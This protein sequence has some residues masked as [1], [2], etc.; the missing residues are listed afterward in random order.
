MPNFP[1]IYAL[2]AGLRH[3]ISADPQEI[4]RRLRAV[5]ARLRS[6]IEERGFDLLTPSQP[7]FASGIV[8]FAHADA[9]RIGRQLAERGVVVWS[10]DGRVRSSV[11][12]YNDA[13]DIDSYLHALDQILSSSQ[14]PPRD[15]RSPA[16]TVSAPA[17]PS[18]T[19]TYAAD[20]KERK[21]GRG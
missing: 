13:S 16:L 9:E 5:V 20:S 3:V 7:A 6:G 11:H 2:Q 19:Q 1:G 8:S 15:A 21:R 12:L 14:L 10:G 18:T 4:D 17:A